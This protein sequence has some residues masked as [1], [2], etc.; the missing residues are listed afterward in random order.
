MMTM[1]RAPQQECDMPRML[2]RFHVCDGSPV[3]IEERHGVIRPTA[4]GRWLLE[5]A[6]SI[7][8]DW[9]AVAF[10]QVEVTRAALELVIITGGSPEQRNAGRVAA[11][12]VARELSLAATRRG[13]VGG[14]LWQSVRI[15][16]ARAPRP[17]LAVSSE[18]E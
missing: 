12:A 5:R 14:E 16:P 1:L 3:L 7:L 8:L 10:H 13:W 18:P 2:I 17:M 4:F 11:R 9:P 15:F 6:A